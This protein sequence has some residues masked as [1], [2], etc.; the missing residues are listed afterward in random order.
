MMPFLKV[1]DV[2]PR[3]VLIH[4][5]VRPELLNSPDYRLSTIEVDRII[6]TIVEVTHNEDIGIFQGNSLSKGFSNIV[7]Y[8][9]MNC[10][11]LGAAIEKY[12]QYERIVDQISSTGLQIRG[13]DAFLSSSTLE[14]P[15]S[16]N[17]QFSDYKMTGIHSYAKILSGERLILENVYFSHPKPENISGYQTVFESPV[18]FGHSTNCLVFD[19]SFL[20]LPLIEPNENLLSFFE[21]KAREMMASFAANET[22]TQKT[23]R[24][25]I[26][27]IRGALPTLEKVA[28]EL[29]ISP[30]TLQ[31]HLK[32]EATSFIQIINEIRKDM[33][34]HYLQ[35]QSISMD[36]IAYILG[37][38]ESSA[39]HRAFKKW[40]FM[41]PGQFRN[42]FQQTNKEIP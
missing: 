14:K 24:I 2:D 29:K 41:T 16:S 6:R 27:E 13:N 32:A 37:F 3:A 4:S 15:L 25:V 10:G 26:G 33:A 39:F 22:Y 5:G 36:E 31:M 38:S 9:L 23:T 30:R 34:I 20:N 12:C 28:Q 40:T 19:R 18:H 17:R 1:K 35:S 8:I 11:T 42:G 7:G 21:L